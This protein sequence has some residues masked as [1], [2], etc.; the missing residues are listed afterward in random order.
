MDTPVTTLSN[1]AGTECLENTAP[2]ASNQKHLFLFVCPRLTDTDDH[3]VV[4]L[5]CLETGT[6]TQNATSE[7]C[8]VRYAQII[9]LSIAV[10]K[11]RLPLV[12]RRPVP[13]CH[14]RRYPKW[15]S[16]PIELIPQATA[17]AKKREEKKTKH[18]VRVLLPAWP[19]ALL[20]PCAP[21]HWTLAV[22]HQGFH[23][24]H[25]VPVT[26]DPFVRGSLLSCRKQRIPRLRFVRLLSQLHTKHAMK[27]TCF[28][29][30]TAV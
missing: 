8:E 26:R 6:E 5:F 29:V 21:W 23:G 14:S 25:E 15:I 12:A 1:L 13:T 30:P 28:A 19:P 2:P 9:G 17:S 22:L 20:H 10:A 3:R 24:F 11:L 16:S 7:I 4:C 27:Q 18:N